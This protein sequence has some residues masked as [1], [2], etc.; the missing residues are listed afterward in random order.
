[1]DNL[2]QSEVQDIKNLYA[3]GHNYIDISL[4]Y[5]ISL[6]EFRSIVDI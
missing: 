1:M 2:T 3:I 5:N 6:A 4:I